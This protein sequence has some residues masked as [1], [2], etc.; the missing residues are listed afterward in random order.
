MGIEIQ[1]TTDSEENILS[2]TGNKADESKDSEKEVISEIIEEE[3]DDGISEEDSTD[4][5]GEESPKKIKKS[6]FKKRIDKLN[7]R[8]NAA[9]EEADYW[10]EQA[11]KGKQS[12]DKKEPLKVENARPDQDDY[13]EHDDYIEALTDWKLD[14][15]LKV[16]DK[17]REETKVNNDINS[18]VQSFQEKNKAFALTKEDYADVAESVDDVEMSVAVQEIIIESDNGPELMYE[19]AK[20][21]DEFERICSLSPLKAASAIGRFEERNLNVKTKTIA[22]SKAPKPMSSIKSRGGGAGNKT[23]YDADISQKEYERLRLKEESG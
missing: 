21:R 1:S 14:E 22:K 18:R 6:G 10:K 2:A 16:R 9:R 19:L 20:N 17:K 15:K 3:T 5:E 12:D 4:E 7:G 23:I 13:E 11:L 8:V